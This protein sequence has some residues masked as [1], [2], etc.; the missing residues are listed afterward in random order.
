M[1]GHTEVG[2]LL[3]S[4]CQSRRNFQ[5]ASSNCGR[6]RLRSRANLLRVQFQFRQRLAA[7]RAS[8]TN[9][10]TGV[11]RQERTLSLHS[12]GMST[13]V[14]ENQYITIRVNEQ[15]STPTTARCSSF[16]ET[17]SQHAKHPDPYLFQHFNLQPSIWC[18]GLHPKAHWYMH[19]DANN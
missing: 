8:P 11:R 17:P 10:L 15:E 5:S 4:L 18:R 3:L 2:A 14:T 1:L 19:T 12:T 7:A 16:S 6:Q 9:R 13:Q